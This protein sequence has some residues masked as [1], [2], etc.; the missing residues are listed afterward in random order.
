M[1]APNTTN[2]YFKYFLYV[3]IFYGISSASLAN[4]KQRTSTNSNPLI[5]M[6]TIGYIIA[7][8]GVI[9]LVIISIN[10]KRIGEAEESF[11]SRLE[12]II[13]P[14]P[15]MLTIGILIYAI[16]LTLLY[17]SQLNQHRVANEYYKY[18]FGFSLLIFIQLG[19]LI[20]S[21]ISQTKGD[22][23]NN[24]LDYFI[25]VIATISTITLAIMQ[26]ILQFFSTDG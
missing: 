24:A 25:Y 21:L 2:K 7:S 13:S 18:S 15:S 8:I 4:W 26:T 20:I 14:F 17:R 12:N 23:S 22:I 19:L 6:V 1:P 11:T 5:W 10:Y 9:M 16:I 3:L